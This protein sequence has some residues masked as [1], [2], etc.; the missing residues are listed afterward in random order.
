MKYFQI[1]CLIIK[2]NNMQKVKIIQE[3][4]KSILLDEIKGSKN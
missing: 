4:L 1:L 3:T 2:K